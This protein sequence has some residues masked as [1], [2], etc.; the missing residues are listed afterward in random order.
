MNVLV[1]QIGKRIFFS[2]VNDL[3]EFFFSETLF[4]ARGSV[5]FGTVFFC[6]IFFSY[7]RRRRTVL[8][9]DS[10]YMAA[11]CPLCIREYVIHG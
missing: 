10:L 5:C 4:F 8:P 9:C 2:L 3:E 11:A 6:C 1:V 7:M